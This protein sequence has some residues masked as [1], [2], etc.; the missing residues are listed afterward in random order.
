[1]VN[2]FFYYMEN[3]LQN[4]RFS[5]KVIEHSR[6]K[7]AKHRSSPEPCVSPQSHT[8]L[9]LG[10][11]LSIRRP[12][13]RVRKKYGC[14]AVYMEKGVLLGTKPLVESIRYSIRDLSGL[15]SA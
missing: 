13:E 3:R 2:N 7:G 9:T 1:M 6:I 5:S 4:S 14:F 11:D 8:V 12:L 15:F 10:P